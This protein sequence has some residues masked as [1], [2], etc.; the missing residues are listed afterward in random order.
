[1]WSIAGANWIGLQQEVDT[2]FPGAVFEIP[3]Y[4]K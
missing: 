4:I 2:F 3:D 1:V